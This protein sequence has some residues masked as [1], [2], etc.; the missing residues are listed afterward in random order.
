MTVPSRSKEPPPLN[1]IMV[2]LC[3]NWSGPAF[4]MGAFGGAVVEVV[5][6]DVVVV[7][8]VDVD[9]LVVEVVEDVVVV[10]VVDVKV[11]D[12][13]VVEVVV[14]E[15]LVEVVVDVV[16][17]VVVGIHVPVVALARALL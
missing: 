8:V 2:M 17:V 11:V 7:R 13:D 14:V 4:A 5:D 6:E 9:T 10:R 1:P 3:V 15:G 16:L 12:V